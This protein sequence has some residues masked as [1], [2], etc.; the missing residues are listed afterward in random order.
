MTDAVFFDATLRPSRSLDKRG[1]VLLLS[2]LVAMNLI[3][4]LRFAAS[5]GWPVLPFLGLDIAGI[6]FAFALN[7]RS[8]RLA[9]HIRLNGE[10]L[11]VTH[12]D[13]GGTAK[14]WAFEPAWVR[15]VLHEHAHGA[16]RVTITTNGRGVAV[17]EFL[18]ADERKEVAAALNRA[19]SERAR[20]L[21]A[22]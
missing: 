16:G 11:T 3:V 19:L 20:R 22:A 15:V 12:V 7:Y 18:T 13:P 14:D 5:G 17:A 10:A 2:L 1:F 6:V 8:G 21:T 4:A 9:E